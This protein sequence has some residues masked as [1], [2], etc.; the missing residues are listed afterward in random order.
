[1]TMFISEHERDL[2]LKLRMMRYLWSLGYYVRKNVPVVEAWEGGRQYTDIDVLAVKVDEELNAQFLICDCKSGVRIKTKE[3]L[4]WLSGVMTY[5]GASR[6]F[7]VRTK[8]LSSKYL[9]LAESLGI[10]PLSE[11]H[12]AELERSYNIDPN[13]FYGSFCEEHAKA[14][15][16]VARLKK[17]KPELHNYV[18]TKYWED[19]PHQQIQSLVAGCKRIKEIKD[20]VEDHRT[21]LLM[22]LLSLLSLGVLRFAKTVL[23]IPSF[24]REEYAKLALLGGKMGKEERKKLLQGFY[25]FMVREIKER[26]KEKYPIPRK[27]FVDSMT[28]A[29]A[30]YLADLVTRVCQNPRPSAALHRIF[31]LLAF[32]STLNQREFSLNDATFQSSEI[33]TDSIIRITKDF[34]TFAQ[35]SGITTPF[36]EHTFD[37]AISK[38]S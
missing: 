28:P 31:D 3:R 30:K 6:S 12:L 2:K 21:F 14:D 38:L 5:F 22:C 11:N 19:L 17:Y 16:I 34:F 20:M 37:E 29:Y 15:A 27:Q 8:M 24:Q 1:M 32:E 26:Y 18:R 25:D 36:L 35:R 33:S 13:R 4:F 7:F 9:E 10:V 23:I